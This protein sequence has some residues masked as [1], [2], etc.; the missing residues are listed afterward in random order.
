MQTTVSIQFEFHGY[1]LDVQTRTLSRQQRQILLRPKSFDVLA[2]LVRNAGRL[3]AK[4]ELLDAVWPNVIASDE[5]LSRCISDIRKALDDHA[6]LFIRT[7][8]GRGYQ[9]AGEVTAHSIA[10]PPS[11]ATAKAHERRSIFPAA[12]ILPAI[13]TV[14]AIAAL[15]FALS[16]E[17]S[18][19]PAIRRSIAVLPFRNNSPNTNIENFVTGLTSGLNS[20]LARIPEMLVISESSTR[21]YKNEDIDVRQVA[22]EMGVDHILT[23]TV[24]R[25]EDRVRISAQLSEGSGGAVVWSHSYDRE[26]SQFLQLQDD[27]VKNVLIGLQIEL[28]HGETARVL[29]RGSNN[30]E[31]WL[32]NVQAISEGFKFNREANLIARELFMSASQ[33]DPGWAAPISGLAWTYREAVRRGWSTDLAADRKIWLQLARKCTQIDAEFYGCYIQLGNYQIENNQIEEGIALREKALQLA[34]NDVSALSGLAWHLVTT[35]HVKRGLELLQR[36]KLVSPIHPPWLIATE[37]YALQMDGQLSKAIDGYK[38]AVVHGK[39]PDWHA[40]LAAVYVEAGDLDSARKQARLFVEKKP[41]RTVTDLMRILR[42]QD[43]KHIKHYAELLR[44]AGIPD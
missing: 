14:A 43:P 12:L 36:A 16:P 4:D 37:A 17:N 44:R 5:S 20:S 26:I 42:N 19:E 30:L 28:T 21:R 18:S 39:F 13:L 38:Y 24:Q 1:K 35:G 25:S 15:W 41:N 29:A 27:I 6:K 33:I 40:R 7:V 32:L 22:K 9:F 31:A 34:P 2:Y 8:P 11:G 10:E 23:G 3:V